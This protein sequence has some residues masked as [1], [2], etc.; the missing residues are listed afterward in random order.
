MM[1]EECVAGH[2][3]AAFEATAHFDSLVLNVYCCAQHP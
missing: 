3:N 1:N 2:V